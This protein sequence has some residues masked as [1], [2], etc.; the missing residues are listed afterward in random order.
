VTPHTPPTGLDARALAIWRGQLCL[1]EGLD[2]KVEDGQIALV[3]GPN[4][5][6]KTTLL[7]ALAG[8]ALPT[9][10]TVCW[11]GTDIRNLAPE[12]RGEI[13]YR[14]HA[15]GLKR[16]LTARENL[17]FCRRIWNAGGNVEKIAAELR[18]DARLDVR[19][20]SLSAGQR[21]RLGL[22]C[23]KLGGA[24]LWILDEPTT[25]LDAA[26]RD[27]VIDWIRRHADDGGCA[28]IATHQPDELAR[29]GTLVIEL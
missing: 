28:I 9:A 17:E 13:A 11:R 16:E 8:L 19:G 26:G 25:H 29:S 21:R 24:R 2:F 10:G 27:L 3:V 7:R 6:G 20:R 12:T 1:F 22:G 5:A 15:D 4:G 23:L 14:G 18:L